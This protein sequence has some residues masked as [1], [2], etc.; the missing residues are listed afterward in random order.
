[1]KGALKRNRSGFALDVGGTLLGNANYDVDY[2]LVTETLSKNVIRSPLLNYQPAIKIK[3]DADL[4]VLASIR[5]L[6]FSRTKAQ[7]ISSKHTIWTSK[8]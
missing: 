5:E 1:V 7:H 8:C 6:Y 3:P 4:A 2:T